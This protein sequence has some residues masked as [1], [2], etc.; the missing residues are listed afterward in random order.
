MVLLLIVLGIVLVIVGLSLFLKRRKIVG[1][2]LFLA[3]ATLVVLGTIAL[4]S[5]HP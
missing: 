4:L 2:V 3:G 1:A 5:F